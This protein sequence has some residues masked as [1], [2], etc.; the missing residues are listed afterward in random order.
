MK[1]NMTPVSGA[2]GGL[3]G[4]WRGTGRHAALPVDLDERER[5]CRRGCVTPA[6]GPHYAD[7]LQSVT[8]P[9]H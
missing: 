6:P 9:I 1:V 5:E 3:W 2:M 8:A 4:G 7:P